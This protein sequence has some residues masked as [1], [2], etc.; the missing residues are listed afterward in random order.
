MPSKVNTAR[1]CLLV[2]AWISAVVTAIILLAFLLS[3]LG[4]GLSGE[5]G[6]GIVASIFGMIGLV[7]AIIVG[8][9]TAF[10][11]L[12]AK[13]ISDKKDWA[14]IAGIVLGI[15]GLTNVPLGTIL[16]IFILIGL[17]D[18]EADTWFETK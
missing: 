7:I 11:F 4:I 1:I 9:L 18:Q 14:K 6:S 16:G 10:M 13:G 17:F 15:L 3:A 12:T 5:T 8:A 2:Q